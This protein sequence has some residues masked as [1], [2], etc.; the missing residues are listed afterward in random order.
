[1]A[2]GTI[3]GDVV[4]P[5]GVLRLKDIMN[6]FPFEDPVIVVR[7]TG[8]AIRKALENGVSLFPALEGRY[9]QVSGLRFG[10]DASLS[11]GN[12]VKWVEVA[13]E[14]LD[15]GRI[16]SVATRGYM[17]RGKDGFSSLLVQSE[18]GE[19][20][21]VVSEEN[22]ILISMILRQYFMSLKVL[23]KWRCWGV[24]LGRHWEGVR[25]KMDGVERGE[26]K[27]KIVSHKHT[28]SGNVKG[29]DGG[30]DKAADGEEVD[31]DEDGEGGISGERVEQG[32]EEARRMYVM[33]WAVRK[34]MRTAGVKSVNVGAVDGHDHEDGRDGD[35]CPDWTRGIAPK[36]EGRI[37]IEGVGADG[38]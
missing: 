29:G 23:R 31:H 5:P 13:G 16:Y 27:E 14:N 3:R 26:G 11:P 4:Y 24:S 30:G 8:S 21:E 32:E 1:M 10:Y 37:V 38:A 25:G 20:E 9:L 22:G 34:W 7:V 2:G 19:A 35:L 6:C 18:G 15:E 12:R 28:R 36:V 17:G 33:R